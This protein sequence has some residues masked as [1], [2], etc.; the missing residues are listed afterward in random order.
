MGLIFD[1]K[2]FS[3]NDGP[4]I[5]TTVFLKGCPL[6]C[7]WCH[8]PEGISPEQQVLFNKKKCIGCGTCAKEGIDECPTLARVRCGKEW[9]LDELM[10]VFE[11]ERDVME[12]SGGGVT[13]CGGEPLMQPDYTALLL[14]ET[15]RRGFH[16]AVDTTLF[17][18]QKTVGRIME[19]CEL[20]LVD[21]KTMSSADH[22]RYCGVPNEPI[23]ANMRFISGAR[24]P[25]WV[26]IPLIEG[27]NADRDNIEQSAAFLAALPTRPEMVNLLPYHDIGKGKHDRLGTVYNPD[28]LD[29]RTP[30]EEA[31]QACVRIFAEKGLEAKI[32]G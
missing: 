32:G 9:P 20:L 24:K 11:K 14:E 21:L 6:H 1:I 4:G 2:R 13:V 30:T 3:I 10:E 23:L 29:M 17:A 26:R 22:Q 15:G 25:F 27:I 19:R 8:N 31:Q 7:V 12:R 5:R 18:P 16:R 28:G